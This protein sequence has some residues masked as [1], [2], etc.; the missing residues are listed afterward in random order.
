MWG[1]WYDPAMTE[2]STARALEDWRQDGDTI[3]QEQLARQAEATAKTG[4]RWCQGLGEPGI[5]QI[6]KL[7]ALRPGLVR[8]LFPEAFPE[9]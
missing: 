7:E 3:T 4:H 2:D 1:W 9:G 8:R 6:R 5:D